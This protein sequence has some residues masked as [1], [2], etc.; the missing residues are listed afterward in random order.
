V[1]DWEAQCLAV[2]L[3][4][5]Q[6]LVDEER[7]CQGSA[8]FHVSSIQPSFDDRLLAFCSSTDEP[9]VAEA[10]DSY[11]LHVLDTS[12]G[13]G[14]A[15]QQLHCSLKPSGSLAWAPPPGPGRGPV[16]LFTAEQRSCL[17]EA[18]QDAAGAWQARLAWRDP[19]LL[20]LGLQQ[21]QQGVLLH[22]Y[23]ANGR[24]R[25]AYQLQCSGGGA[26][27]A[28]AASAAAA[29]AGE[30]AEPPAAAGGAGPAAPLV[31]MLQSA[32]GAAGASIAST[33]NAAARRPRPP[34][35]APGLIPHVV[36]FLERL[37][38][39]RHTDC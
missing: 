17:C 26:A 39:S 21:H 27:S 32:A 34:G 3:R 20:T 25:A 28:A 35:C 23:W 9:Q 7:L 37:R 6:L 10:L 8:A 14:A 12:G 11:T 38:C 16:L 33:L 31:Q 29:A 15:A 1:A 18:R 30:P 5:C 13:G 19:H 4:D 36:R 22:A 24:G 2:A